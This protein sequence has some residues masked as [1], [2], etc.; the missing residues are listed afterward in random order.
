MA[1]VT[2]VVDTVRRGWDF[3]VSASRGSVVRPT[4]AVRDL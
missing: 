4:N 3:F 2:A 1:I